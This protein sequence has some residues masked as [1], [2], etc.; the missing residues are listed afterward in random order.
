MV[1]LMNA[2]MVAMVTLEEYLNTE[3]SPDC[4]FV[5]GAVVERTG[6]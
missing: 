3:Y 6:G 1:E 2:A 5:D 4:E